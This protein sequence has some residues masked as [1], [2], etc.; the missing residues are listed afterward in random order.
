MQIQNELSK[1]ILII[2]GA[3]GTMIQR[4][5]LEEADYR[6][7]R[8]KDWHTDVKG[9]N[10]LLNITQPQIIIDIHKEYLEAG[11]DIIETNTFSCTSIAM[12]DYDMQ[13]FAYELNVEGARCARIAA[14]EYNAKDP[15]KPRF[16]AGAIGPLNKTLSLSPDVNNPGYR[17]VTFDEVAIAYTEQIRGL[18]DGGVDLFLIETI[19]DTLNAKA[20]IYAIK[21]YFRENPSGK[22]ELP[23]MISGTITDASGR[24]LSGQTLEAFYTSIRHARPISVGLNCALGATQMRP[25]IEELSQIAECYTSAY[26]NAGLPNAFGE[27]DEQ[28]HETAH[29]IE[30]WA[31]EGFVNIVG[32]CCGT[33]PDHIKHIADQVKNYSPRQLPVLEAV[34]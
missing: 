19:F 17:A 24:T 33:T 10:D 6:G 9:N 25:H 12:A 20:A 13:S 23:I 18:A 30:D 8:F 32:G 29:I 34:L 4:R 21:K 5:K 2:D 26:P 16:V 28:P 27:Y 15:S 11:A 31:K 14:D 7:E 1:R 3:M 22:G